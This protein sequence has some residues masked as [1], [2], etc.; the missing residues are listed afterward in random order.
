M[1]VAGQLGPK[2]FWAHLS[3]LD[4]QMRAA[5]HLLPL[6]GVAGW[7]G[8]VMTGDWEWHNGQLATAELAH[9]DPLGDGPLVAV[10]TT[11][12]LDSVS[13]PDWLGGPPFSPDGV[14]IHT[15]VGP[16]G[17]AD[18]SVDG[19]RTGFDC[20]RDGPAWYATGSL[21]DHHLSIEGRHTAPEQVSLIRVLDIEPYVAGRRAYLRAL[22]GEA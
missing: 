9:G 15:E 1:D 18:I 16:P 22:R 14:D 10:K 8:V 19:Q 11:N 7:P 12:D 6:Y 20:W 13:L 3:E 21:G 5:A 2:Q 17:A 4:E